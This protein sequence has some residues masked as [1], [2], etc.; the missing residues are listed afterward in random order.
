MTIRDMLGL[1][2]RQVFTEEI[3][4]WIDSSYGIHM[5]FQV[6]MVASTVPGSSYDKKILPVTHQCIGGC[7]CYLEA[8]VEAEEYLSMFHAGKNRI[9]GTDSDT[10]DFGLWVIDEDDA[11]SP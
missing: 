1:D 11:D 6:Q 10:G 3:G 5:G 2:R 4:C 7:E 9:F 8:Y